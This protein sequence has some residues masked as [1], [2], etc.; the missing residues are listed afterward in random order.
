MMTMVGSAGQ[1]AQ[2]SDRIHS[3]KRTHDAVHQGTGTVVMGGPV[4]KRG[5]RQ[6]AKTQIEAAF[7]A[8]QRLRPS[9]G[10][11]RGRERGCKRARDRASLSVRAVATAVAA[12]TAVFAAATATWAAGLG[13]VQDQPAAGAA[14]RWVGDSFDRPTPP[15]ALRWGTFNGQGRLGSDTSVAGH[16]SPLDKLLSETYATRTDMLII[17][18]PGCSTMSLRFMLRESALAKAH[19]QSAGRRSAVFGPA[20]DTKAA[21][22]I[23]AFGSWIQ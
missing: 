16:W 14:K 13:D 11:K 2:G 17:C 12:G 7:E 4:P 8:T 20:G 19:E 1:T 5:K 10:A 6:M 18:D 23:L 15:E 9:K 3:A 22:L 21:V